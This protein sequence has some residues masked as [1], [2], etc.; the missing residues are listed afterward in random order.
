MGV[1]MP[2]EEAWDFI[3]RG[4]TGILTTL[5]RD[6]WPV[7]LPLWFAVADRRIYIATPAGAKKLQRIA[8]DD[9]GSFLV[10]TGEQWVEL[11]AVQLPVRAHVLDPEH[12]GDEM[13]TAGRLFAERYSAF[14]PRSTKMPAAT[15]SH[16][17]SQR[18]VRLEPAGPPLSWDNTKIRLGQD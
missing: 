4:H 3:A 6:G 11:A 8:N 9:R 1:S 5:R 13:N 10:E 12:D 7:A 2:E 17:G 15:R 18:I 14:R 16:Y